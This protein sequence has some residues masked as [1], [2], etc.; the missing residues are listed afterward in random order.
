MVRRVVATLTFVIIGAHTIIAQPT[1]TDALQFLV[2]VTHRYGS[3]ARFHLEYTT[4]IHQ[5]SEFGSFIQRSSV[6]A[7]GMPGNR[8]HFE[9]RDDAGLALVVSDG[10][11][12]WQLNE[13]LGQ[14]LTHAAGTYGHPF[15]YITAGEPQAREAF[16]ARQ[17]MGITG[18]RLKS[19]HWEP[20]ETVAIAGHKI[21]CYVISFGRDDY[22]QSP[23]LKHAIPTSST[24]SQKVWI[25]KARRFFVRIERTTDT[26]RGKP[27]NP[28]AVTKHG[29]VTTVY[30]TVSLDEPVPDQLFAFSPPPDAMLVATFGDPYDGSLREVT[31]AKAPRSETNYVGQPAPA[32]TLTAVDGKTLDLATLRGRPVLL[33]LWATWCGPCLLEMPLLDRISRYAGAAG[34]SLITV[35]QDKNPA[36]AADYLR[37][38]HYLWPNYH[39]G[40]NGQY[41]QLGLKLSQG[42]PA[43]ML[44]DASGKIV[45]YHEGADDEPGLVA[46]I[47]NLGPQFA[48]SMKEA[49]K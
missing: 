35:D 31:P 43:L 25:D 47:K 4:E 40:F 13:P 8:Y 24:D 48:A 34:L 26:V 45:Y 1:N 19:A 15:T 39:D 20:D 38:E 46:A 16:Y 23:P 17:L 32:L 12:E 36:D 27:G 21:A 33:D 37:K 3:A 44:V 49:E 22:P 28:Y 6:V 5:T 42:L 7:A 2:D 9:V 18:A 14:Y 11:T 41:H 29:V 30:S 10:S